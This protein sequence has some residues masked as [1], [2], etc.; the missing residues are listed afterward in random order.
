MCDPWVVDKNNEGSKPPVNFLAT[1]PSPQKIQSSNQVSMVFD[2]YR[3]DL[4]TVGIFG[5]QLHSMNFQDQIYAPKRHVDR[6][7]I[8]EGLSR[9]R[10]ERIRGGL[11]I[12]L[13]ENPEDRLL[14]Y[15]YWNV[16]CSKKYFLPEENTEDLSVKKNNGISTP[17]TLNTPLALNAPL[18]LNTPLALNPPLTH[19]VSIAHKL[20]SA[21]IPNIV[22]NHRNPDLIRT[23]N[24]NVKGA[25]NNIFSSN[26]NFQPLPSYQ[27]Q[28]PPSYQPQSF[29]HQIQLG[30]NSTNFI[31][32]LQKLPETT[33][34]FQSVEAK[35]FQN[36]SFDTPKFNFIQSN[37]SY[38]SPP[39]IHSANY[40]FHPF[41][42]ENSL[43]KKSH[44]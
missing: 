24:A 35:N 34:F 1:Y 36:R 30:K 41:I 20:P 25:N 33:S 5:L 42:T 32:N 39:I 7:K 28:P 27:L 16:L 6:Q 14:I 37:K 22:Y 21:Q 15:Q 19:P 40:N 3:S 29:S 12:L 31:S 43:L 38:Q 9:I 13:S 11:A 23:N 17:L 4:F 8:N 10:Q 26:A 2:E 18:A 44:N